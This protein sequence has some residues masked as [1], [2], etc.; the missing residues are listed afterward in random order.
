MRC[1]L[2][3]CIPDM[4][5]G[6]CSAMKS[7]MMCCLTTS[8]K[9]PWTEIFKT[10]SQSKPFHLQISG[11]LLQTGKLD[12]ALHSSLPVPS[13]C[14]P[15][16]RVRS[17]KKTWETLDGGS[18]PICPLGERRSL[19]DILI[20]RRLHSSTVQSVGR[21][22]TQLHITKPSPVQSSNHS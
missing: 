19:F 21:P 9:Q 12:F 11:I 15:N 16:H 17:Q 22:S 2:L 6:V 18:C 1:V 7:S 10:Q 5:W 4:R 8:H 13:A 20:M 14:C 3:S